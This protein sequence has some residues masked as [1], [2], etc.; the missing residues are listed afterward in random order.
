MKIEF[1]IRGFAGTEDWTLVEQI[2]ISAAERFGMLDTSVTSCVPNTIRCYSETAKG[3]FA[4]GARIVG[5]IIIVDLSAGRKPSPLYPE[6]EAYFATE[7]QRVFG[8]R[9]SKAEESQRIPPQHSLPFS[10]A[11]RDFMRKHVKI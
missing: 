6:V 11:A 4:T 7:L 10:D 5:D 9:V 8:D 1:H 3:G 2:L